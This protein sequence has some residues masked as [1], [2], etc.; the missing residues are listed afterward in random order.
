MPSQFT[1]AGTQDLTAEALASLS[2][3]SLDVLFVDGLNTAVG[4]WA[5]TLRAFVAAGGGLLVASGAGAFNSV[6]AITGHPS[7]Q[8]LAPLGIQLSATS[9]VADSALD[10]AAMP[11]QDAASVDAQLDCLLATA[12]NDTA[13]P[14]GAYDDAAMQSAM[15]TFVSRAG[16]VRFETTYWD[17]IKEV[18]GLRPSLLVLAS[19]WQ[20]A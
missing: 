18:R 12:G 1:N 9:V 19:G 16:A 2:P 8:L 20:P 10:P 15:T 11:A 4:P 3:S 6:P 14:C 5:G 13:S 7:N 17:R